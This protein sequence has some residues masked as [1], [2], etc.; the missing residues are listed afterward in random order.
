MDVQSFL[1]F[2]RR[3][4]TDASNKA[5]RKAYFFAFPLFLLFLVETVS[6]SDFWALFIFA[7][8]NPFIAAFSYVWI[9]AV[10][11]LAFFIFGRA[12][13]FVSS[14]SVSILAVAHAEK[15]RT[16]AEPL[17]ATDVLAHASALG[18]LAGFSGIPPS[19]A[20][21]APVLFALF[22]SFVGWRRFPPFSFAD[23]TSSDR[24]FRFG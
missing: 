21:F 23:S 9:L 12:S 3:P 8:A 4:R 2:F 19:S 6:R 5:F 14:L 11:T 16:L 24:A 13:F 15:L 18:T 1:S 7:G 17:Y 22:V 20:V 10:Q